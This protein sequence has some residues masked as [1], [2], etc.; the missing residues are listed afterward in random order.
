[1]QQINETTIETLKM[2]L[3]DIC[4]LAERSDSDEA[5]EIQDL[6]GKALEVLAHQDNYFVSNEDALDFN[7]DELWA[8]EDLQGFNEDEREI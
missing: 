2:L 5:I 7:S 3:E 4:S 1:M 6:A 8:E